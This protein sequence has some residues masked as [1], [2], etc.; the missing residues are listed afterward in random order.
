MIRREWF[1]AIEYSYIMTLAHIKKYSEIK[2]NLLITISHGSV[3]KCSQT[4]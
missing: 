4:N 2:K 3:H 1:G